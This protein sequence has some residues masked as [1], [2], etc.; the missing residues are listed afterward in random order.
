MYG[1]SCI[2][3]VLCYNELCRVGL[4]YVVLAALIEC[5]EAVTVAVSKQ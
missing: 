4:A 1:G 3:L 2:Y 5:T